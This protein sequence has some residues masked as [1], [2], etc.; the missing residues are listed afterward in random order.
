[1]S[2]GGARVTRAAPRYTRARRAIAFR[3]PPPAA[4]PCA[5]HAKKNA[6]QRTAASLR[7]EYSCRIN[8]SLQHIRKTPTDL[9]V[10]DPSQSAKKA[11]CRGSASVSCCEKERS[12]AGRWRQCRSAAHGRAAR[13]AGTAAERE[14]FLHGVR[15]G[16]AP[17]AVIQ[18]A[19]TTDGAPVSSSGRGPLR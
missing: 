8:L 5:N 2:Q 12:G 3:R 13:R 16:P 4:L 15:A 10:P 1:M 6:A 17:D 19:V 7:I 14:V 18:D 11:A 9:D